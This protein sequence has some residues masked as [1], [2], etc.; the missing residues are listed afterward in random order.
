MLFTSCYNRNEF[1]QPSSYSFCISPRRYVIC[2]MKKPLAFFACLPDLIARRKDWERRGRRHIAADRWGSLLIL[3]LPCLVLWND[4]NKITTKYHSLSKYDVCMWTVSSG[5]TG[6]R[7]QNRN[8]NTVTKTNQQTKENARNI[9]SKTWVEDVKAPLSVSL[10]P[11]SLAL[12]ID[13]TNFFFLV[14]NR[15]HSRKRRCLERECVC[16]VLFLNAAGQTNTPW[17]G[18]DLTN[19]K[20]RQ[21]AKGR[22]VWTY[23]G[24]ME[25]PVFSSFFSDRNGLNWVLYCTVDL[26]DSVPHSV[27]HCTIQASNKRPGSSLKSRARAERKGKSRC[28]MW[29]TGSFPKER[30]NKKKAK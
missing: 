17:V 19:I 26:R 6:I 16:Q 13:E 2:L 29:S 22:M 1:K 12:N 3:L 15:S 30:Q 21:W 7:G 14:L 23:P 9:P 4:M 20:S 28:L 25:V 8:K 5:T 11:R 24:G 18:R 27:C 10:L